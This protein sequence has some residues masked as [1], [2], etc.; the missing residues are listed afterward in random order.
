MFVSV[1]FLIL[2]GLSH[3]GVTLNFS[4]YVFSSEVKVV[5]KTRTEA[6][7]P[8][9]LNCGERSLMII[10]EFRQSNNVQLKEEV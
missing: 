8:E 4:K 9:K 3:T 7:I 5:L 2:S 10:D 1:T 6:K